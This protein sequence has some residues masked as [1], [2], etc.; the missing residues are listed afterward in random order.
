MYCNLYWYKEIQICVNLW[1]SLC[2]THNQ[3]V[4]GSNPS[5]P[6]KSFKVLFFE[7]LFSFPPPKL[8]LAYKAPPELFF[9]A[10][11]GGFFFGARFTPGFG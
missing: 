6:T 11:L 7:G 9:A 1:K 4:D 8:A 2:E 3:R 10:S 5:G